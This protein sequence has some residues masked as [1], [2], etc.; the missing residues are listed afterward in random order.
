MIND[1]QICILNKISD[2]YGVD[3]KILLEELLVY[4]NFLYNKYKPKFS[5]SLFKDSYFYTALG[6]MNDKYKQISSL[7]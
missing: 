2:N 4:E 5:Q 7:W 1:K 6:I 3:K